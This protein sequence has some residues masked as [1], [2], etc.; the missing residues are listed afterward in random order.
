MN[1]SSN[2]KTNEESAARHRNGAE[3]SGDVATMLRQLRDAV[4]EI[5][6]QLAGTSKSHF[7]VDEVAAMTGRVPYTVRSWIKEGRIRAERVAGTGPRGRLLIP[8]EE[9]KKLI[10]QGHG[11]SVPAVLAK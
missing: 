7:T 8:R 6:S 2:I 5:R 1:A 4:E 9:L 10:T 11:E 3:E